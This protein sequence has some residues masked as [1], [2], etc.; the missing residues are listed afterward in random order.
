[1]L[2]AVD[3]K[4]LPE[5]TFDVTLVRPLGIKEKCILFITVIGVSVDLTAQ[6]PLRSTNWS[7]RQL[8]WH[9]IVLRGPLPH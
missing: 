1:M 3:Q 4:L 9:D 8:R 2:C 6:G 5:E 7:F